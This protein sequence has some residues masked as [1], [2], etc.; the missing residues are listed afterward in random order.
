MLGALLL[1]RI[2]STATSTSRRNVPC[3]NLVCILSYHTSPIRI[4]KFQ[5]T[6]LTAVLATTGHSTT[7]WMASM[8][9][10]H[11]S[12]NRQLC[13]WTTIS[14][15]LT[16]SSSFRRTMAV[17]SSSSLQSA[18]A[19]DD[20]LETQQEER[21]PQLGAKGKAIAKGNIVS[22]FRGGFVAV[23]IDDDLMTEDPSPQ[24]VDM[25]QSLPKAKTSS[26]TLGR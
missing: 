19:A 26:N 9:H 25:A 15:P 24:V 5:P 21:S 10:N 22:T 2:T 23:R 4:M 13:A 17:F 6:I 11:R 7:A 18:V 3:T 1:G 8:T 16:D 12:Q 20:I 14:C